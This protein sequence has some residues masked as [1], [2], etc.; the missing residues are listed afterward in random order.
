[1]DGSIE[2]NRSCGLPFK[3]NRSCGDWQDQPVWSYPPIFKEESTHKTQ[4]SISISISIS[5]ISIST[6]YKGTNTLGYIWSRPLITLHLTACT[7]PMLS[8]TQHFS[9]PAQYPFTINHHQCQDRIP[10]TLPKITWTS[11]SIPQ[12]IYINAVSSS[13]DTFSVL[14]ILHRRPRCRRCRTQ[15]SSTSTSAVLARRRTPSKHRRCR[16]Q[17]RRQRP[18]RRRRRRHQ[19][20]YCRTLLHIADGTDG[21]YFS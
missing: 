5:T 21:T 20:R 19:S 12:S 17:D 7:S 9:N 4:I 3:K 15:A 18:H 1:M 11:P 10:L 14:E 2:I 13:D 6:T 8:S 16:T